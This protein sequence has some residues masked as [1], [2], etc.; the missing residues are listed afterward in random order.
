M[1]PATRKR[2]PFLELE[3]RKLLVTGASSGIGRSVAVLAAR[4]GAQVALLARRGEALEAVLGELEGEGHVAVR[5]DVTDFDGIPQVVDDVVQQLGP[6]DGLVHA[7]GIHR[8]ETL[9][10]ATPESVIELMQVNLLSS[11]MFT[12]AFRRPKSHRE[13]AGVVFLSSASASVGEP[14]LA[15]YAASKGAVESMARSLAV[16]LVR[17]GIRCNVVAAGVVDTPLTE[18]LRRQIGEAAWDEVIA[19]HPLGVGHVDDVA[20][21]VLYLVSPAS[22]WVLGAT[23]AVDGGYTI[24]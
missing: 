12:K 15:G 24:R 17:D 21:A 1:P 11:M 3:G 16:E 22:R 18:T 6:L 9:R 19:S 14:A 8:V 20:R 23:F 5:F 10:H 7:A 4:Y 2:P 13:G